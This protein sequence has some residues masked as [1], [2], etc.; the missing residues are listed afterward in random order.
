MFILIF[1]LQSKEPFVRLKPVTDEQVFYDKFSYDKSYFTGVNVLPSLLG[2][3]YFD[4]PLAN[5]IKCSDYFDKFSLLTH[6]DEQNLYFDKFLYDKRTCSKASMLAFEQ[7][8]SC[9][10]KTCQSCA[11]RRANKTCHIKTCHRK[12]A[13]LL[14]ALNT[15]VYKL[16]VQ[17]R[18]VKVPDLFLIFRRLHRNSCYEQNYYYNQ[19]CHCEASTDDVR[20]PILSQARRERPQNNRPV[21]VGVVESRLKGEVL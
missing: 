6:T 5:R 13:H 17:Q 2:Q 12:L 11:Y 19:Q 4:N 20:I 1:G 8:H 9:H 10:R 18:Q 7:V 21:R 14:E 15:Q 3:V 16:L